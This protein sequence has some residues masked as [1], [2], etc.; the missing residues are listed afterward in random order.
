MRS[1]FMTW[2]SPNGVDHL[3]DIER[4]RCTTCGKAH[5]RELMKQ[6]L[7]SG[8][9]EGVKFLV[10]SDQRFFPGDTYLA[11]RNT[12]P[13]LLT[14]R[15]VERAGGWIVPVEMAYSFD[16]GECVKIELLV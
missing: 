2:R 13:H 16:L 6:V 4:G 7:E 1:R 3:Q 8:E 11:A 9:F 14:V 12:G 5:T 15:Y 10:S